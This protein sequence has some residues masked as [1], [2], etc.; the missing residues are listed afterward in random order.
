MSQG[1]PRDNEKISFKKDNN[2]SK[3]ERV[4]FHVF[5][6]NGLQLVVVFTAVTNSAMKCFIV[7]LI[8]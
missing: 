6:R 2:N 7:C 4:K 3:L 8:K 1:K 5:S